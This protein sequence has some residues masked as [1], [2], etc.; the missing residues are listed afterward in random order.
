[1]RRV[2][3]AFLAGLLVLSVGACGD[4]HSQGGNG[5]NFAWLKKLFGY[6]VPAPVADRAP[7]QNVPPP[8]QSAPSPKPI[9]AAALERQ[10]QA[11][12]NEIVSDFNF[13]TDWVEGS[14]ERY[15]SAVDLARGP[16]G[17]ET[18]MIMGT[19]GTKGSLEEL[20][21]TLDTEPDSEPLDGIARRFAETGLVLIP[22]LE[23]AKLYY[24]QQDYKD[25]NYAKGRAMHGPLV[26]AHHD[27][28]QASADL[29]AE[30]RRIGEVARDKEMAKLKD[31]GRLLRYNVMLNLK[32]SRQTLEFI[33]AELHAK[34]DINKIDSA[35]LKSRNDAMDKSLQ[36]IRDLSEADKTAV[37]REYGNMGSAYLPMY[38]SSSETF[39][40]ATKYIQRSIRDHEP[41][42]D[43]EFTV[44]DDR[45]SDVI[46]L[47]ND[48]V[49]NSNTLNQ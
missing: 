5:G 37:S 26:A 9:D 3:V 49:N 14:F 22:L 41:I 30:I 23:R 15:A 25:D 46:R 48:M 35:E 10:R 47:F 43:S 31:E 38:I 40:K 28:A 4:N 33:R 11:K 6:D 8:A 19:S 34:S 27:F 16:T 36:A 20:L 42:S 17:H 29:R 32:Q 2:A 1:M 45:S 39:L 18:P 12:F 21:H 24:D 44:G 13:A 7:P